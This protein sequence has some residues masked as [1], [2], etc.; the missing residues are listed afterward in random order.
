MFK[1]AG[2]NSI[3]PKRGLKND[4]GEK[5]IKCPQKWGNIKTD[6]FHIIV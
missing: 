1:K 4:V 3:A 2:L 6:N 5:E